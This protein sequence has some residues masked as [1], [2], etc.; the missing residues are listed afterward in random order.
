MMDLEEEV[1]PWKLDDRGLMRYYNA[2]IQKVKTLI[3]G[4]L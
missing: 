1:N 4:K 3:N 2:L